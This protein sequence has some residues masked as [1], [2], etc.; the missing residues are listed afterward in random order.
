[1]LQACPPNALPTQLLAD[2]RLEPDADSPRSS[3]DTEPPVPVSH[4]SGMLFDVSGGCTRC[5][6]A[7]VASLAE[8]RDRSE[9][10]LRSIQAA[11]S[12]FREAV[13]LGGI[14]TQK[15]DAA[16]ALALTFARDLVLTSPMLLPNVP[17]ELVSVPRKDLQ[18]GDQDAIAGALRSIAS[19]VRRRADVQD[20][21]EGVWLEFEDVWLEFE[22]VGVCWTSA[23][24]MDR[25]VRQREGVC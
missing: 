2:S 8:L 24:A 16:T 25:R 6:D 17:L 20:E 23:D 10:N 12:V 18:S 22:D 1:M 13:L 14:F 4:Q 3:P 7:D 9:H 19:A 15:V 5:V 11:C 21:V